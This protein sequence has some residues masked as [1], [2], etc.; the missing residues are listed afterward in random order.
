MGPYQQQMTTDEI[1]RAG[2]QTMYP[3]KSKGKICFMPA[4]P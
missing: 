4:Q 2:D 3:A 1:L